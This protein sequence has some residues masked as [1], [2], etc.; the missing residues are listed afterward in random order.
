MKMAKLKITPLLFPDS[1]KPDEEYSVSFQVENLSFIP[2][3]PVFCRL[4][5]NEEIFWQFNYFGPLKR[6]VVFRFELKVKGMEKE[7]IIV[8]C[9]FT[10]INLLAKCELEINVSEV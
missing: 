6:V 7:K 10:P 8:E 9:G 1:V 2:I 3:A 4:T 5:K